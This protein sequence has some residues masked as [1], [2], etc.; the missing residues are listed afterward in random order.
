MQEITRTRKVAW[1]EHV[2]VLVCSGQRFQFVPGL[3][4][5]RLGKRWRCCQ[6]DKRLSSDGE[7]A[8]TIG[9]VKVMQPV[10]IFTTLV[11]VMRS[12]F[13]ME[14]VV[15]TEYDKLATLLYT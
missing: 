1:H 14:E 5:K 3:W 12:R 4:M 13:R 15:Y 11:H 6:F 2:R 10:A 9:H 8:V 7:L